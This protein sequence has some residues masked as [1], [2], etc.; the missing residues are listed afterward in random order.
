[1]LYPSIYLD[2][3]IVLIGCMGML[4]LLAFGI[5]LW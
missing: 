5:S 3:D 1:M 2:I 4:Y